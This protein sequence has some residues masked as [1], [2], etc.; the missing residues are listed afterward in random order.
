MEKNSNLIPIQF[1]KTDKPSLSLRITVA[2]FVLVFALVPLVEIVPDFEY[3]LVS[4]VNPTKYTCIVG[5]ETFEP[6]TF[7]EIK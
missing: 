2:V 6:L 5:W 4:S 7:K 3:N 1:K